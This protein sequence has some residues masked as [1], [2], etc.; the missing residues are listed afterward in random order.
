MNIIANILFKSVE[1]SVE[2]FDFI[3]CELDP[4]KIL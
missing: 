2:I 3:G 1:Y 4:I